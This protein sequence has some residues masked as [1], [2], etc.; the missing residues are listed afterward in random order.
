MEIL[1]NIGHVIDN[2]QQFYVTWIDHIHVRAT[3]PTV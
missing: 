1:E 3:P 2:N